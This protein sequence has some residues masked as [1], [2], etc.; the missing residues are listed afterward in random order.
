MI[1]EHH[2]KIPQEDK[3]D[4]IGPRL[5]RTKNRN[6]LFP[7]FAI[8]TGACIIESHHR[9][10]VS[11]SSRC[12]IGARG[13]GCHP[14][15]CRW[16]IAQPLF[17]PSLSLCTIHFSI[18]PTRFFPLAFLGTLVSNDLVWGPRCSWNSVQNVPLEIS[19]VYVGF[20]TL[21]SPAISITFH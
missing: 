2:F 16:L 9:S 1:L 12:A 21:S 14:G 17:S 7:L 11:L 4:K 13:T 10:R 8:P 20:I 15:F 18:S 3:R 19:R 5:I 6:F